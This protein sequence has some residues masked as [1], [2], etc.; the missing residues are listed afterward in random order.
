MG[1]GKES[2]GLCAQDLGCLI[3]TKLWA[4]FFF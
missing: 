1:V 4:F 2:R 3:I